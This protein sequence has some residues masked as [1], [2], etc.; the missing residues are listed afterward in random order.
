M[1]RG[2]KK[3]YW[4]DVAFFVVIGVALAGLV[5]FAIVPIYGWMNG[6]PPGELTALMSF[7]VLFEVYIVFEI[8]RVI[9][10]LRIREMNAANSNGSST[11][12]I[13]LSR[14]E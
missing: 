11:E 7:F 12:E 14:E 5:V 8:H 10:T 13:K 3:I 1:F 2:R 9:K 6:F 4:E